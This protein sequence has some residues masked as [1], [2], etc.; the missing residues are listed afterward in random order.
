MKIKF[1]LMMFF[2][3][4]I[5]CHAQ[6]TL[7]QCHQMAH[8]NYP[9][10]KK[11]ALTEQSR[12]FTVANASKGMLPQ[13]QI[14]G[15]GAAFTDIIDMS[16]QTQSLMGDSKNWIGG[17]GVTVSQKIYDGGDISS[18]KSIARA[19]A[20]VDSKYLDV[21][22][23][24]VNN[25]ID[26]LFFGILTLEEELKQNT[27]L[28]NDLAL[29]RKT[30]DGMMHGGIANQ[31]D[32]DAVEVEQVKAQQTESSMKESRHAY[33][34]MLGTFI[35]K[36]LSDETIFMKPSTT[37]YL[38]AMSTSKRP[39]LEYY[40]AQYKL[41]DAEKHSL[42]VQL[43]PKLSAFGIG[44][45]HNTMMSMMKNDLF[46]AG[47]TLSWS[48]S[49][50]YTRKNNLR[51]IEVKRQQIEADR[52]TFLFNSRLQN[53]NSSSHISDLQKKINTDERIIT[54]RE[55]IRSKSEKKVQNGTETI[56]EMLRDVNA[57]S[58]ARQQKALHEIEML[59][60]IYKIKNIN[61]N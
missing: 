14:T 9:V 40:N 35:G 50:L 36:K 24:E 20:N 44:S 26:Q 51:S 4:S 28:Q 42:D 60:E 52:E 38:E 27:L 37:D 22:M 17:V 7:G 30:V 57:V 6:I 34:T 49:P 31:S 56:N 33:L 53:E 25:R 5:N 45:Y 2:V 18:R 54:L 46:A 29:S 55:N 13:V 43:L 1:L 16:S 3:M 48:I 15:V 61:N 19:Q 47:L 41:L 21:T 23:Y 39:E 12:D 10:I 8:D 58:E 32:I 11:Y 59:Q